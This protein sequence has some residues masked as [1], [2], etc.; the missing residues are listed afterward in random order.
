MN[1][2]EIFKY[3]SLISVPLFSVI[4][5]LLIKKVPNYSFRKYTVS[6]SFNF[7]HHPI[8]VIIFRL[9]FIIKALLDFSFTL[10]ILN[11]FKIPLK[12]PITLSLTLSAFLFG[13]LAYFVEGKYKILHRVIIYTSGLLWGIGH[14]YLIWLI[15]NATFGLFTTI[16][17]FVPIILGFSFLFAKKT[18]VFV[19]TICITI[20]YCWLFVFVF[21]Y[22]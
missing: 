9:N 8:Q 6:E 12:S 1:I 13:T 22:L 5:F 4:A 2:P 11:N 16:M 18:N 21:Q 3:N 19:Q 14:I 17:V 20:W 10:Y 7:L 15:G